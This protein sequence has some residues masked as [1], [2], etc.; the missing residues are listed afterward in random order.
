MI[1][2]AGELALLRTT[3]H[4]TAPALVYYPPATIWTARVTA[5]PADIHSQTIQVNTVVQ[6]RAPQLNYLVWFGTTAGGNDCGEARFW[7]YNAGTGTLTVGEHNAYI[8]INEYVTILE[9]VVPDA[10]HPYTDDNDVVFEAKVVAYT[11]EN[12]NYLPLARC[13][14]H[15]VAY[16]DAVTGLATVKF[17]SRSVAIGSATLTDCLWTLPGG[18]YVVGNNTTFGTVGVP[19]EVTWDTVGNYWCVFW[20]QD[21]NGKWA[22]RYFV[23]FIRDR[24]Q[25]AYEVG[26]EV[27]TWITFDPIE[28]E[29]ESGVFSTTVRVYGNVG[30]STFMNKG[31]V[32]LF[33]EDWYGATKQSIGPEKYREN[34]ILSGIIKSGTIKQNWKF[35]Y[36]EFEIQT[37]SGAMDEVYCLA[38]GL[39]TTSG[40]T[41]AGWHVLDGMTYNL[42]VH[43]VLT[44]HTTIPMLTDV[45][46]NL[47]DYTIE[48][49]DLVGSPDGD[50]L[51]NQLRQIVAGVRGQFGCSPQGHL[52]FEINPQL[53]SLADPRSTSYILNTTLADFRGEIDLGDE[54]HFK[55]V[56][57]ID[58][59]GLDSESESWFS[60]APA[61]PWGSGQGER[62]DGIRVDDQLEANEVA[63]LY[64]GYRNNQW[65]EIVLPFRG[66]YRC[67]GLYPI[68]PIALNLTASQNPRGLVWTNVRCWPKRVTMEYLGNGKLV[69]TLVAEQDAYGY[70]GITNTYPN[71][72]VVVPPP[73]PPPPT[74]PPPEP[75]PATPPPYSGGTWLTNVYLLTDL[76]VYFTSTFSGPGDPMPT[77]TTVNTGLPGGCTY[78]W[79]E[80]DPWNPG[81]RQYLLITNAGTD[82][83][84]TRTSGAW[85]KI[86]DTTSLIAVKIAHGWSSPAYSPTIFAMQADINQQ[87][88]LGV[89][90]QYWAGFHGV[91]AYLFTNDYGATWDIQNGANASYQFNWAPAAGSGQV[92]DLRGASAYGAGQVLYLA[93]A[94]APNLYTRLYRSIDKGDSWSLVVNNAFPTDYA[95]FNTDVYQDTSYYLGFSNVGASRFFR[96]SEDMGATWSA[97]LLNASMA[98]G[99]TV[100]HYRFHALFN[101]TG[102]KAAILR[103][104][105]DDGAVWKSTNAGV[106]WARTAPAAGLGSL[107]TEVGLSLCHDADGKL[108]G[109]R[110]GGTSGATR[111]AI[112]VSDD[113]GATWEAK[114]G[115]DPV[116]PDSDSI[117]NTAV[118]K[119]I[120]Q[121]WA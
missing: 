21:S 104:V 39:E 101:P 32:V 29:R 109:L 91:V 10:I 56:S 15:A 106:S 2:T 14:T 62:V 38:G 9:Y 27:Y 96:R 13:G 82:E 81:G 95:A 117:P 77:W 50:K 11:D 6:T 5:S 26:N 7:D 1:L 49:V 61:T 20:V 41:T 40:E 4:V 59:E 46:L 110:L 69:T 83:V 119:T 8:T 73:G 116:T 35:G 64:E 90:L 47:P 57:Q 65:S 24:D 68:E 53:Q 23:V 48:F 118:V 58:F 36:V 25:R 80:P 84:Y 16:R 19:N 71:T 115:P 67:F 66:N 33:A 51:S 88:Y 52:Y 112:F 120:L 72:P 12:T 3:R 30:A 100:S 18:T 70:P 108:Y 74:T 102:T 45:Y 60:L 97:D 92:G 28:G 79:L 76:G 111:R 37:L 54:L 43:H 17:Y 121:V 89:W 63:G 113:E 87:G 34:I 75:P 98:V 103:V 99:G 107:A 114:A 55:Q 86:C 105:T 31:L 93:E 22:Q 42:A 85:S 78:K 44:Q 94:R